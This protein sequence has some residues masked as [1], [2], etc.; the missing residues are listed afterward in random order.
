ML[1]HLVLQ[2]FGKSYTLWICEDVQ[3]LQLSEELG[4]ILIQID[5]IYCVK[6]Y[7]N[8]DLTVAQIPFLIIRNCWFNATFCCN[9]LMKRVWCPLSLQFLLC[10]AAL[11]DQRSQRRKTACDFIENRDLFKV[12]G[13][14][15]L[16]FSS[17][18]TDL[19]NATLCISLS[20]SEL[21]CVVST[22]KRINNNKNGNVKRT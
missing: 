5:F 2:R 10:L 9:A 3:H 18:R 20:L 22:F 7:S 12:L 15:R 19:E 1:G 14:R 21:L 16:K 6:E 17:S 8:A 4:V 11:R 13:Q